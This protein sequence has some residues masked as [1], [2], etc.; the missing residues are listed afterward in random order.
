MNSE[1]VTSK[2]KGVG[3]VLHRIRVKLY[4][5]H[6]KVGK[7]YVA[8]TANEKSLSVEEVCASLKNRGGF[9]GDYEK[10]L[11]HVRR[12]HDEAAFLLCNGFAINSGFYT[13]YLNVGGTLDSPKENIHKG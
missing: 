7:R 4:P 10:L 11:D 12:Y 9:S 5:N 3:D 8:R 1:S 2:L 13:V 6:L